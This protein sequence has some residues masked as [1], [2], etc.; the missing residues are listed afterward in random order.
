MKVEP[1]T[2]EWNDNHSRAGNFDTW[3]RRTNREHR[4]YKEAEYSKEE[5]LKIFTKLYPAGALY[6]A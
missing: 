1:V 4:N 6:P 3:L 2:F 5:G